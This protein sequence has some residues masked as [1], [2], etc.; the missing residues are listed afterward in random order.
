M[1]T[2]IDPHIKKDDNYYVYNEG[3]S[4]GYF[5]KKSDGENDYEGHCWPGAS[6]WLDF[7]NPDVRNF[8]AD[9]FALDQYQGTTE[10][11]SVAQ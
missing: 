6:M 4:K 11:V 8:W 9:K 2:V 10:R 5:V 1:V 3:R 7:L